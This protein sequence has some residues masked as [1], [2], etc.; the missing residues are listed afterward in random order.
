MCDHGLH[1]CSDEL[2]YITAVYTTPHLVHHTPTVYRPGGRY[3]KILNDHPS[4]H[5][6]YGVYHPPYFNASLNGS[7]RTIFTYYELTNPLYEAIHYRYHYDT[8][9]VITAGESVPR[10]TKRVPYRNSIAAA[11]H[12]VCERTTAYRK[13]T[14]SMEVEQVQSRT[15]SASVVHP[16]GQNMS[17][18]QTIAAV[19]GSIAS[20][21]DRRAQTTYYVPPGAEAFTAEPVDIPATASAAA[22]R[23]TIPVPAD[24]TATPLDVEA[25]TEE[26]LVCGEPECDNQPCSAD[27]PG[28]LPYYHTP[29]CLPGVWQRKLATAS[30]TPIIVTLPTAWNMA[31]RLVCNQCYHPPLLPHPYSMYHPGWAVNNKKISNDHPL[32]HRGYGVSPPQRYTTP[33]DESPNPKIVSSGM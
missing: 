11:T 10:L 1:Y 4:Y 23:T 30:I 8:P 17:A 33:G 27:P 15:R 19:P 13:E 31:A 18:A 21:F 12:Q 7:P 2:P 14:S 20:F 26:L 22:V 6:G 25:L 28:K 24:V 9:Q 29:C 5:R 3:F 16:N 32:Y